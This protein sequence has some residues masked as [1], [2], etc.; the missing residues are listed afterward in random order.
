MEEVKIRQEQEIGSTDLESILNE[1]TV[2]YSMGVMKS[3]SIPKS[4]A[5]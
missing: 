2:I 3:V 4:K 1:D 5:S